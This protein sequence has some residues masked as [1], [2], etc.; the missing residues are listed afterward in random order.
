[1]ATRPPL[2][3][4]AQALQRSGRLAE[5]ESLYLHHLNLNPADT[6]GLHLLGLLHADTGRLDT[7]LQLLRAAIG[8]EGPRPHL[9]RNLGILLERQGD[10]SSAIACFRQALD[11]DRRDWEL[12]QAL[13]GLQAAEGRH[14]DAA[15]SWQRVVEGGVTSPG[16]EAVARCRWADQ[17]LLAGKRAEALEH[18]KRAIHI[19]PDSEIALFHFGVA[20]MQSDRGAEAKEAFHRALAR[21]PEHAQAHNNLAILLQLEGKKREAIAHYKRAIAASPGYEGALF[22]LGSAW[23]EAD[24]PGRAIAIFRKLLKLQPRHAA[25]WTHLG[26]CRLARNEIAQ[27]RQAYHESL[28]IDP[29]E[30]AAS[31]NLGIAHLL[32]GEFASGWAGYEARFDVAGAT[33][34]RPFAAP[35]WRGEPLEGRSILFHAEQGLGDSLQFIRFAPLLAALGA[36]VHVECQP[37]LIPL[38]RQ[39]EGV[40]GWHESVAVPPGRLQ[41]APVSHLPACDF[42]LPFLSAPAS[43]ATTVE[44]IPTPSGYLQAPEKSAENWRRHLGPR[45]GRLRVGLVWGGNPNHKNDRNRS[46]NAALLPEWTRLV[47]S[48]RPVEWVNLQKGRPAPEGL[49][50]AAIPEPGDFFETAGLLANVDLVISVDTSVAHLAGAMGRPVWILLPFA[51]DWRW[52][53]DRTDSPWYNSARLFR[54]TAP[55][56]WTGV[57]QQVASALPDTAI[58][59][60]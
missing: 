39:M 4:D 12:W 40:A 18:Y 33:P 3:D 5:A 58:M 26:N 52:M 28:V 10:R 59:E 32:E 35:V 21:N 38:L 16:Q 9:C 8:I 49:E 47:N 56:D 24:Q 27:A 37:M 53:L 34:R 43:L 2:L 36:E 14:G 48:V 45:N 1:M 46:L 13:A 11:A 51:P 54:Q 60:T 23:Q 42:Q 55:G 29:G 15:S 6:E 31:W 19:D 41:A 44:T 50:F 7:A 22:N 20:L 57:L 25:A 17:L 30:K